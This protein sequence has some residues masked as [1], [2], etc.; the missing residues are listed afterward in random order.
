[1]AALKSKTV[2]I[3][4]IKV[5]FDREDP[6]TPVMVYGPGEKSSATFWCACDTGELVGAED[7]YLNDAE[8]TRLHSMND[9]AETFY[10]EV[11]EAE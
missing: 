10:N 5:V 4:R 7:Y 2:K 8:L 11:R 6:D 9:E 3:G 1:M